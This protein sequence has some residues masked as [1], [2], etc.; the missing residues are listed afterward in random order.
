MKRKYVPPV[1]KRHAI[2]I[3]SLLV[4]SPRTPK[5]NGNGVYSSK[6]TKEAASRTGSIWDEEDDFDE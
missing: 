6:S 4:S 2:D 1:A 5:Y 3:S